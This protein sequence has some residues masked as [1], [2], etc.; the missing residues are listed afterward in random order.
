MISTLGSVGGGEGARLQNRL[1]F[2]K[3]GLV[4]VVVGWTGRGPYWASSKSNN[5]LQQQRPCIES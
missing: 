1:R 3:L 2:L 4:V 5:Q